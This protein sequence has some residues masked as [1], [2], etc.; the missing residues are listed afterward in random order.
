MNQN[1]LPQLK[2]KQMNRCDL[3]SQNPTSVIKPAENL[4]FLRIPNTSEDNSV[5]PHK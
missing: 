5:S 1:N 3:F 2:K 4:S